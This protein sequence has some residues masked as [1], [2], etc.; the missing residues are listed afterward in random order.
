MQRLEAEHDDV[1]TWMLCING[2]NVGTMMLWRECCALMAV[3]LWQESWAIMAA[4]LWQQCC[5]DVV[6]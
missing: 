5:D 4:M 3:M 1:V 2:G 6:N